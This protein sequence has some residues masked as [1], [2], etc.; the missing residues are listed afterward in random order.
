MATGGCRCHLVCCTN[1][2]KYSILENIFQIMKKASIIIPCYNT[3]ETIGR[4]LRAFCK[5]AIP[6]EQFEIIVV[7]DCSTDNTAEEMSR[8][9]GTPQIIS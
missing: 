9:A 4:T 3:G 5:Q 7:D 1:V 2:F 8:E 6:A